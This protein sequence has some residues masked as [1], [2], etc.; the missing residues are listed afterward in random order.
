MSDVLSSID[1]QLEVRLILALPALIV[2][3]FK[4]TEVPWIIAPYMYMY[5]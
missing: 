5:I 4:F 1:R 2:D 3:I